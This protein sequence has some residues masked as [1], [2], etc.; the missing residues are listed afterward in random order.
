[1]LGHILSS[2]RRGPEMHESERAAYDHL[3]FTDRTESHPSPSS[4]GSGNILTTSVLVGIVAF[5]IA[6]FLPLHIDPW[7]GFFAGFIVSFVVL[8]SSLLVAVT[9]RGDS[10]VPVPKP[11]VT[12][13]RTV[14]CPS[15]NQPLVITVRVEP[16]KNPVEVVTSQSTADSK[17]GR[18]PAVQEAGDGQ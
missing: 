8:S 14:A 16:G 11:D 4:V 7:L 5:F 6:A 9:R 17:S 12:V 18:H 13:W 2:S 1:M 3:D 10:P 15:C